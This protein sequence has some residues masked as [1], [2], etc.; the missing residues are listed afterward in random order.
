MTNDIQNTP[1]TVSLD[2][3]SE[4]TT[5]QSTHVRLEA[6]EEHVGE[7]LDRFIS[8]SLEHYTRSR[9]KEL[10]KTGHIS[11][12]E[13]VIL[14]PNCRIKLGDIYDVELPPAAAAIPLAQDIPLD[15]AY[16]DEHLI[17]I[18]K[19]A[20]LL[21]LPSTGHWS[22]TSGSALL[23]HCGAGGSGVGGVERRGFSHRLYSHTHG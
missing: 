20:G 2:E 6:G 7:R 5:E 11:R 1:Q 23:Y 19:P 9:V 17:V 15:I 18:D 13:K 21:V 16:E 4:K 10:I 14:E 22:G 3:Q 8:S 12:G